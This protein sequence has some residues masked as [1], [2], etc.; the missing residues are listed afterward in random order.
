MQFIRACHHR[1][2]DPDVPVARRT[3][4]GAQLRLEQDG[5]RQAQAD[6]PQAERGIVLRRH[7]KIIGLLVRA[8]VQRADDNFPAIHSLHD[9]FVAFKQFVLSRIGAAAQIQKF[10]SEQAYALSAALLQQWQIVRARDIGVEPDGMSILRDTWSG[11][12]LPERFALRLLRSDFRCC[13]S[14]HLFVR[15]ECQRSRKA[16]QN[17]RMSVQFS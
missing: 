2:H 16:I 1:E 6:R 14:Q 4:N 15:V 5:P 3:Q 12:K 10:A 11:D 17:C 9:C 7:I 13:F 8:D